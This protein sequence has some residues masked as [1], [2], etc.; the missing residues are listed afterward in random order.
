LKAQ[1][2]AKVGSSF[3]A[4]RSFSEGVALS[5]PRPLSLSLSLSVLFLFLF[6]FLFP[7]AIFAS[8]LIQYLL[9]LPPEHPSVA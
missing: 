9:L 1:R 4:R 2:A 3:F 8:W 5:A 7:Q 6:L